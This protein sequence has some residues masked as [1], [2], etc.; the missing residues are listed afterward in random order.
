MKFY[1]QIAVLVWIKVW[2][3]S[4]NILPSFSDPFRLINW[5]KVT[6]SKGLAW[7]CKD[8]VSILLLGIEYYVIFGMFIRCIKP[9]EFII[10]LMFLSCPQINVCCFV[11]LLYTW[12]NAKI[13]IRIDYVYLS[14]CSV[15]VTFTVDLFWILISNKEKMIRHDN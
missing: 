10:C 12:L 6:T 1:N 5:N 14:T 8:L 4:R 2:K 15:T 9:N 11:H 13:V 3:I 7:W